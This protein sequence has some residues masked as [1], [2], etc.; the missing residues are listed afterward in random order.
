MGPCRIDT[1]LFKCRHEVSKSKKAFVADSQ[2]SSI[3]FRRKIFSHRIIPV[4]PYPANQKPKEKEHLTV[5]KKFRT[6]GPR[7][8]KNLYRH[9][10]SVERVVSRLKQHLNLENHKVRGLRSKLREKIGFSESC[11]YRG[12]KLIRIEATIFFYLLEVFFLN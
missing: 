3:K 12:F 10:V 9:R 1:A 6:H 11:K 8:L 7:R 4:I 5:D 2:Y